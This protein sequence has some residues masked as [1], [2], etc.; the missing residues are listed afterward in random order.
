L[1]TVCKMGL[2]AEGEACPFKIG[3]LKP[4]GGL[5]STDD[6]FCIANPGVHRCSTVHG[7]GVM[8]QTEIS[9]VRVSM[10]SLHFFFQFTQS[11]QPNCGSWVYSASNRNKY[12][13]IFLGEGRGRCVSLTNCHLWADCLDN[14]GSSTCHIPIGVHGLLQG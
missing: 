10:K 6:Q 7:R 12:L 14:V 1:L 13:K 2:P 11:F 5:N 3:L 4:S 8:I 9:R